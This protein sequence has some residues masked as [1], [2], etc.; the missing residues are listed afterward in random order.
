VTKV[1]QDGQHV[2]Y[3]TNVWRQL[4]E[5]DVDEQR[6]GLRHFLDSTLNAPE[7]PDTWE[8][9]SPMLLPVLRNAGLTSWSMSQNQSLLWKPA[10][11]YLVEMLVIDLGA[12]VAYVTQDRLEQWGASREQAFRVAHENLARIVPP[13]PEDSE[14]GPRLF[15]IMSGQIDGGSYMLCPGWLASYTDAVG[16]RPIAWAGGRDSITIA[17]ATTQEA[18]VS[19]AEMALDDW[20]NAA[21]PLSPCMYTV[22][23]DGRLV[24]VSVPDDHPAADAIARGRIP[25]AGGEYGTQKEALDERHQEELIDVFVASLMGLEHED[26]GR[27]ITLAVWTQ[28]ICSWLPRVERLALMDPATGQ[29]PLEASFE[30]VLELAGDCLQVVEGV[31]PQRYETR[32]WSTPEQLEQLRLRAATSQV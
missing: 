30:D 10:T 16:G 19:L 20:N 8:G 6:E 3:L 13:A 18:L 22:T 29:A 25:L 14:D 5:A 7:I 9:L 4:S 11:P 28:G 31:H 12:S 21:R 2:T 23:D 15:H 32:G 17:A 1:G 26:G 24:P 27:P